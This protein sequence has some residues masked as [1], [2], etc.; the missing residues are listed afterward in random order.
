MGVVM[1]SRQQRWLVWGVS[2][3]SAAGWLGGFS[4]NV[5][6]QEANRR[7]GELPVEASP[8]GKVYLE[9]LRKNTPFGTND[10]D[11]NGLRAGMGSRRPPTVDGVQLKRV[12]V[13][14]IPCEWVVAPGAATDVR[15]LYIHGGG[16]ISGSGGFYLPLA[17]HLS[18]MAKCAVLLVDYRLAPEHPFPAGLNDCVD[19]FEWMW[20]QGPE[21][22]S[23]AR[24]TFVAGDS[25]GGNL[26]LATVLALRDRQKRL[27]F[28]AIPISPVTDFTLAS[29]S[30]NS[31]ADPII[32]S[33][34]M[35]IFRE[36]YLKD[37]STRDP[38]ASPVF[39]DYRG[40][41]PLLIQAGEH[42]MLRD[43]AVRVSQRIRET[44]GRVTLEVWKGM[45]HVFQSHDPLLPE[46]REAFDHIAQFVR[47]LV[48]SR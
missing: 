48:P 19:V 33:R 32:S 3:V 11:F 42:E 29:D 39:A 43:D 14:E 8:E 6:G 28:G 2:L 7:P 13:G 21:G 38:L 34:T 20:D 25:A 1:T 16:F 18:R 9:R 24:A 41:P 36:H 22:V 46:G 17:S 35:P 15:V 40:I 47:E 10:F 37:H 31:V 26:T 5:V 12:K 45:F 44:G 27:P 30:L 23:R 4:G